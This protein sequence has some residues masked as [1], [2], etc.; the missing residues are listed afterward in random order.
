MQFIFDSYAF[1]H[2]TGE[3][4]FRYAFSDGRQFVERVYFN[5]DHDYDADILDKA[6]FLAF[7][8]IGTSY[9]KTFPTSDVALANGSID[10]WQANFFNAVYQEGMS[11]FAFENKLTR[12]QL[13]HFTSSQNATAAPLVYEGDGILALESGGKDSLLVASLLEE[14]GIDFTPWYVSSAD[15][16]P[17]VLGKFKTPLLTT[18]RVLDHNGLQKAQAEGGKNGHVPVTYILKSLALVQAILHGKKHV[19]VSIAHEGEEAHEWI[20]D[21]PINHQWSKTWGAERSFVEYVEK[22]ITTGLLIGSPLRQYSELKMAELFVEHAW[23][24]Y[25]NSFSSCNLI[26]YKQGQAN[27]TLKWCGKCPKC[28]NSYLLFASFVDSPEL[29]TLF[30]GQDLFIE[31]SLE[32]TFKGLLGVDGVMKPFECIGEIDELRLAYHTAQKR[33]GYQTLPFDVPESNFD[34]RRLYPAQSWATE[35]LQ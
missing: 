25:G 6:L 29:Q 27:S 19:L 7:V 22:Y 16:Y 4:V 17:A 21:L 28:A 18:K 34:Y 10:E 5:V 24:K 31:P 23:A 14:R 35:M 33:H 13:A 2:E 1:D 9:Y 32:D 8:L 30:D 20:G 11:Q 15:D 12:E 26:N 3:A